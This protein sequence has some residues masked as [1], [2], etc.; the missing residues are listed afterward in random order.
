MYEYLT[1]YVHVHVFVLQSVF[2]VDDDSVSVSLQMLSLIHF[3]H[4][5]PQSSTVLTGLTVEFN[6]NV[7][8]S[9]CMLGT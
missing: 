6:D 9:M 4:P 1:P 8:S 7:K 2:E 3:K 5:L